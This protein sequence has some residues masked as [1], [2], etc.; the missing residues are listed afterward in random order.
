MDA[1]KASVDLMRAGTDTPPHSA[2]EFPSGGTGLPVNDAEDKV[3]F[4]RAA[5]DRI[6]PMH[7]MSLSGQAAVHSPLEASCCRSVS[8][9]LGPDQ[10][11]HPARTFTDKSRAGW[12]A[13]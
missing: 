11:F 12:S 2:A 10:A 7:R 1:R 5:A 3:A 9:P 4:G 13:E 8:G 6:K